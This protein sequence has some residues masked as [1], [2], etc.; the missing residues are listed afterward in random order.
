MSRNS[1]LP[2]GTETS[3]MEDREIY[4]EVE[5]TIDYAFDH[6]FFLNMYE[7]LKLK[8]TKKVDVR[9][10]IES[11]TKEIEDII[12]DLEEYIH[13]GSDNDHKQLREGYGHLGKPEAR[14]IKKIIYMGYW[15][16]PEGTNE[17]NNQ[18]KEESS[19][20]KT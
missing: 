18:E 15:K 7:Y 1:Q 10:F 3:I 20:N 13:G 17:K 2:K 12:N 16:M 8:K 9:E 6:K 5:R 19:L 11:S 14:K 4:W